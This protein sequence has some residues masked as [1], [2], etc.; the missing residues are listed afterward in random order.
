MK[1]THCQGVLTF[2][3]LNSAKHLTPILLCQVE[4]VEF[5]A[6][7]PGFLLRAKLVKLEVKRW[8]SANNPLRHCLSHV[9]T[10][11]P[12]PP[13]ETVRA[14]AVLSLPAARA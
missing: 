11:Q 9:V 8:V 3:K 2:D 12:H 1:L 5:P 7:T 6:T 4:L 13:T 14:A 10:Y